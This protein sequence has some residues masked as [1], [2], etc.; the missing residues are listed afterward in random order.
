MIIP[1]SENAVVDIRKL[2]NYCLN[3]EHDDGKHKA[4]LFS[5]IL[6]MTTDHAEELRQ[7]LLEVIQAHEA[8]LGRS[9]DF[10]QRYTLDFSIEWQNKSATLRSGW[11]IEHGSDIPRL[12]TCYPL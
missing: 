2:R 6:G 5:A 12:T 11:I 9:D 1:N 10:G 7:I 4:R 3:S 8:R